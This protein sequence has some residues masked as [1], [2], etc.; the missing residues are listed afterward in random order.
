MLRGG[1]FARSDLGD[2]FAESA[3]GVTEVAFEL[4]AHPV[5]FGQTEIAVEAKTG[6]GRDAALALK[7]GRDARERHMD[8][9]RQTV[10]GDIHGLEKIFAEDFAGGDGRE[11]F[12][13]FRGSR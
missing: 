12:H 2:L 9:L 11:L 4:D 7:D 8:V 6:V 5:A 3:L 1:E 13:E 10:G